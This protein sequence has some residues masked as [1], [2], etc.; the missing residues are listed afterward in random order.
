MALTPQQIA[1]KWARNLANS[2]TDAKNS[3]TAMTAN[4]MERA[5]SKKEKMKANLIKSI[6]DGSWENGLRSVSLQ[7]WK[8]AY[9]NK[10]IS[11][12]TTG[13]T[14]ATPKMT[15][16]MQELLPYQQSLKAQVDQM[17]DLTLNDSGQ[18]MLAWMNGMAN[19]K[20]S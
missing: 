7:Q 14:A 15:A 17:P 11:R 18:K 1:E 19:F 16:F 4:P 12:M 20:K 2:G 9:I 13:A 3:V 8:D 10:G 6:D 5:I